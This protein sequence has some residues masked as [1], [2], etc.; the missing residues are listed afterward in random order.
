MD[1]ALPPLA[2]EAD[3]RERAADWAPAQDARR[4]WC[5]HTVSL[6]FCGVCHPLTGTPPSCSPEAEP[7]C[8]PRF[9]RVLDATERKRRKSASSPAS[10]TSLQG[11]VEEL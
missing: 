1:R 3:L 8:A 9:V 6:C 5:A 2:I 4:R 10:F 7:S 11:I